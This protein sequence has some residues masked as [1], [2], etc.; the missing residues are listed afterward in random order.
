MSARE[1]VQQGFFPLE[2]NPAAHM[3]RVPFACTLGF[4]WEGSDAQGAR[5]RLPFNGAVAAA[6]GLA[7][8]PLA[9]LA[10]L[11]HTCSAAVYLAL[12]RPSLIATVDL[13]CE[14][15]AA[16]E[17]GEDVVCTALTQ[18]LDRFAIVRATAT[19]TASGRPLA[20]AS[21]AYAVGA[22]PGMKGKKVAPEA[23]LKTGIVREV[24]EGFEQMLGLQP[25]DTNFCLPFHD[26]LV[27]AVSLPAVHGGATAAALALAACGH[28]AT[29]VERSAIWSPLTV[30]VH[31]LRA[32]RAEPL[33]L[34]P[35]L[36]KPG[37][38]SCV[39]GVTAAQSDAGKEVAHAECLLVRRN[40]DHAGQPREPE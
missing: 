37:A 35:V 3:S 5:V 33:W 2:A 29:T 14:F 38:H 7:A 16:P 23:W 26:R 13:R 22:H 9:I 31:Y 32:V 40:A 15:A 19:S 18:Y 34:Q 8:D 36:R 25:H 17:P 6:D 28:A 30:S 4:I 24:H 21:S 20:Y 12:P 11:D 39:I 27:G 10:L 1:A